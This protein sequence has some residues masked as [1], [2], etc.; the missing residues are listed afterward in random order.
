MPNAISEQ[1]K[2][3]VI[4]DSMEKYAGTDF[5]AGIATQLATWQEN[6]KQMESAYNNLCKALEIYERSYGVYD[7]RTCKIKRNLA[8]VYIGDK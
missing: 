6:I 3:Q 4:Y 1:E 7:I 8:L 5:A 2:A